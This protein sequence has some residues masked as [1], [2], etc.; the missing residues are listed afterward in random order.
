[1]TTETY[2]YSIKRTRYGLFTSV[3]DTGE[4][5]VTAY[6]EDACR[7]VTDEIHIPVLKGEYDGYTSQPFGGVVD[8]KL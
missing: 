6:T 1:M 4:S 5:M 7:S 8:G 2:A 3:L